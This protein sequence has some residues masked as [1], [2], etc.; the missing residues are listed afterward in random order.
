MTIPYLHS[1]QEV[2]I[3]YNTGD[4]PVQ[5]LC[6]DKQQ[7]ICKYMRPYATIAYKL[8]CELIGATFAEAWKIN[9]PPCAIVHICP[10]HWATVTV[11]HN[12]FAPAIGF[13]K[14]DGVIDITPTSFRQTLATRQTLYQLLKI[15]L[16]VRMCLRISLERFQINNYLT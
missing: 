7:Y 15:A 1:I 12:S 4:M 2:S 9:T 11:P 8:V 14:I 3:T 10:E 16:F 13:K 5:V 6:A